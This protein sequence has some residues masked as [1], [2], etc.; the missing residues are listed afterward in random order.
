MSQ[1]Y[2]ARQR[3][4]D[5]E[6]ALKVV[7]LD[8]GDTVSVEALRNEAFL[9]GRVQHPHIVSVVDHGEADGGILY[10]AMEYLHGSTLADTLFHS[11]PMDYVRALRILVQICEAL[12]GVHDAGLVYRDIKPAQFGQHRGVGR[13]F[14]NAAGLCL[15]VATA[16]DLAATDLFDDPF[17]QVHFEKAQVFAKAKADVE[18]A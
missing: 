6:I 7:F 13:A 3:S 8:P 10:L 14:T 17:A 18:I 2:L 15:Q 4:L 1:V 9:A 12:A 5:R 16:F 11:G